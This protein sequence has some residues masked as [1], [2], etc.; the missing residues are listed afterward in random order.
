VSGALHQLRANFYGNN[1]TAGEPDF[2]G[3]APSDKW[4]FAAA[5]GIQFNLP[6]NPGDKFWVEATYEQGAASYVGFGYFNGTNG[7]FQRFSGS[8][9]AAAWPMDAVFA[10]NA[11]TPFS[12]LALS[13]A[14]DVTAAVEHYWTPALRTSV[15]GSYTNFS[16]GGLG[17][18]I[19]CSSPQSPVRTVA[20]AAPT[21][22]AALAGCDFGFNVWGVGTRTI[23]NPV[24]NLD[25]GVEV[26]YSQID[27]N[28][29]PA[30]IRYN[31]AGSGTRPA[32]LYVPANEGVWNGMI[33]IQRNFYP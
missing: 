29:D 28:M 1:F 25:I 21:G 24:K 19:M 3:I 30:L 17:N 15:W 5:G 27:V 20:G 12:G 22:A 8:N 26:M 18:A 13:T 7:A 2:T 31:F 4:G 9:L 11:L 23:W 16:P 14:W 10:N 6:W 32:G 33:R